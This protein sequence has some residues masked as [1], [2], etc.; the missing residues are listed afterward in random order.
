MPSSLIPVY[1]LLLVFGAHGS[2]HDDHAGH[3]HSGGGDDHAGHDHGSAPASP[4]TP[5]VPWGSAIGASLIVCLVTLVG[6][7]FLVP[8]FKSAATKNP[9]VFGAIANAFAAGALLAAA[10]YLIIH[11]ATNLITGSGSAALFGTL[12]LVGFIT[13]SVLD[14]LV[15]AIRGSAK[16]SETAPAKASDEEGETTIAL[17]VDPSRRAR[18]LCGILLGDFLHNLCDGIFMGIAFL[19]CGDSF[20][21]SVTAATIYHEIAQEVSDFL[22]LTDP[23]QGKLS[24]L[25]ALVLNFVSGLSVLLG[26]VIVLA[27]GANFDNRTIG[28]L[29]AFSGGV[30]VQIGAAECMPK[31]YASASS[32]PLR[33][34]SLLAFVV[35]ATAIGLVLFDHKHC[36]VGGGHEGHN[37]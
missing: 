13:A 18:V 8:C 27:Q 4:A 21:W 32:L 35:G 7:A 17:T 25:V 16:L 28:S 1:V 31:V 29:L 36:E 23:Q 33:L 11:E 20:G 12:I 37:H 24:A 30:Y 26:A 14:L 15:A 34:G 19:S 5:T 9:L 22:V 10:F 3:D 2:D 6:V